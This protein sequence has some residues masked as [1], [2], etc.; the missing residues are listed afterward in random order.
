MTRDL[1]VFPDLV[2]FLQIKTHDTP[3]H[4]RSIQ[5]DATG[6]TAI[7]QRS[8]WE[9]QHC[10]EPVVLNAV[11]EW[12]GIPVGREGT[13]RGKVLSVARSQC[14]PSP[15]SSSSARRL[16]KGFVPSLELNKALCP[17]AL[18]AVRPSISGRKGGGRVGG[19][20]F[21]SNRTL[22]GTDSWN[23]VRKCSRATHCDYRFRFAS[24][25]SSESLARGDKWHTFLRH[26]RT[27]ADEVGRR[28]GETES[29][30]VNIQ[31]SFN[32]G[33]RDERTLSSISA[34]LP[35]ITQCVALLIGKSCRCRSTII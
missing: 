34:P 33:A 23:A 18:L 19:A 27:E 24:L 4:G 28:E 26:F 5:P 3:F 14:N 17:A 22:L 1:P 20:A 11:S 25:M 35:S 12:E 7:S 8:A 16:K 30:R 31:L 29:N 13:E 15:S 2:F 32:C 21:D 10:S 6:E 9:G